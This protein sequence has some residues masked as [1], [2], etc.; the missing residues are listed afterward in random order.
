MGQRQQ[1]TIAGLDFRFPEM[2][3]HRLRAVQPHGGG[4]GFIVRF[5]FAPDAKIAYLL[6]V[7]GLSDARMWRTLDDAIFD[8]LLPP[9][10]NSPS[11]NPARGAVMAQGVAGTYEPDRAMR[12]LVFLKLPNRDLRVAPG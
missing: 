12:D 9:R 3:R 8:E 1:A 6:V 2:R 7:R 11:A 4:E 10:T 5:F